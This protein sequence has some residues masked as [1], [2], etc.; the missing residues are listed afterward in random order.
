MIAVTCDSHSAK[1]K[2][3]LWLRATAERIATR[4]N[5]FMGILP[6]PAINL[7]RPFWRLLAAIALSKLRRQVE[8]H[9]AAKRAV[10]KE[11]HATGSSDRLAVAAD[12][13]PLPDEEATL[14]DELKQIMQ[15]S[16]S[17]QREALQL[18]LAGETIESIALSMGRSQRTVRRLLQASRQAFERRLTTAQDE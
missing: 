2:Q 14:L 4:V 5:C 15:A 7:P 16:S 3:A 13:E 12:R 18:R 10:A 11:Q 6:V 17:A 9:T 8:V 1:D